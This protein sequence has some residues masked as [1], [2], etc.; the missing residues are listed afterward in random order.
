MP[1]TP[2][3]RR[4][5]QPGAS[6]FGCSHSFNSV[7]QQ[8]DQSLES[9]QKDNPSTPNVRRQGRS[10]FN[11][12]SRAVLPTPDVSPPDLEA[13][14][15]EK[16]DACKMSSC[17]NP[18]SPPL[19]KSPRLTG[20][21]NTPP[22]SADYSSDE[23]PNVDAKR[24]DAVKETKEL[25][26]LQAAIRAIE[27][28][29]ESSPNWTKE[30]SEL[31]ER[32]GLGLVMPRP[33]FQATEEDFS[34]LHS[35]SSKAP[36][37]L[38][39]RSSSMSSLATL[40]IPHNSTKE[41]GLDPN[42]TPPFTPAIVR[43][44]S[45]K[46]VRPALRPHSGRSSSEPGTPTC[47]KAVHFD[48]QL[49]Q[50]RHFLQVDQPLAVSAGSSVAGPLGDGLPI[51]NDNSTLSRVEWGVRLTNFPLDTLERRSMPIWVEKTFL[52]W[53]NTYLI[54]SAVVA[55]LGY[56]KKAAARFTFDSWRTTS[57]VNAEYNR[58]PSTDDLDRFTFSVSLADVPSLEDK[59]MFFCVRYSVNGREYWD[60]N[61]N[62][63]F[64]VNF[65]KTSV[66]SWK[67]KYAANA[68]RAIISDAPNRRSN[69]KVQPF[70]SRYDFG[71]SLIPVVQ[72][73]NNAVNG[74]QF[75][76]EDDYAP[77]PQERKVIQRSF[78]ISHMASAGVPRERG[79]HPGQLAGSLPSALL[80]ENV[81]PPG[82]IAEN[83]S[84]QGHSYDE[85]LDKY[86][87][88]CTPTGK[89]STKNSMLTWTS[90][91]WFLKGFVTITESLIMISIVLPSDFFDVHSNG[92]ELVTVLVAFLTC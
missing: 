14:T 40:H 67:S 17:F 7:V 3:G 11:A 43:T 52:S 62:S 75:K 69:A 65:V 2:A 36:K 63:N 25:G 29:W 74:G 51:E 10:A 64:Q 19:V 32:L 80:V 73:P 53:D 44:K 38:H 90:V 35:L 18:P 12:A 42:A 8:L 58:N 1:Y 31:M 24:R 56:A 83:P 27:Q 72:G 21:T 59:T 55:N 39:P 82:S 57:E 20:I 28:H 49:E 79:H 71:R 5:E 6:G 45:G 46:L 37:I 30:D 84:L 78:S 86:C 16:V 81:D 66:R 68:V 77:A 34:A 33:D 85:F 47:S 15:A 60:N 92:G 76:D 26:K 91:V 22:D 41:F 9:V 54:G 88:V 50:V 70:G 61:N 48:S 87:F 13:P 23:E 89:E 4:S